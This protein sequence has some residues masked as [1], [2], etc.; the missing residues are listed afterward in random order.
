LNQSWSKITNDVTNSLSDGSDEITIL[1]NTDAYNKSNETINKYFDI[2]DPIDAGFLSGLTNAIATS[3]QGYSGDSGTPVG[4]S[5]TAPIVNKLTDLFKLNSTRT[6]RNWIQYIIDIQK[7]GGAFYFN[8]TGVWNEV[9]ENDI[10]ED[11]MDDIKT[12]ALTNEG[13][14]LST[15]NLQTFYDNSISNLLYTTT[16]HFVKKQYL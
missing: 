15:L 10:L 11:V 8:T 3:L 2:N 1:E 14:V 9:K 7:S 6:L 16:N 5:S 4:F 12:W 13:E